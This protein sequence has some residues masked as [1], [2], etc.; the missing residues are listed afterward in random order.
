MTDTQP[1]GRPRGYAVIDTETSG[2]FDFSKPA[3]A[4]GQ[5]RLASFAAIRLD[6]DLNEEGANEYLIKPEGWILSDEVMKIN[7]LTME[8]LEKEGRPV[9]DVLKF[10]SALIERGYVI[11]A[12]NSQFDCKVMRGEMRRAGV[13]DLF[14]AT[15]NICA[16]RAAV[17]VVK[18]PKASGRGYKF[19]KLS[20]AC[21]HFG[22][23]QTEQHSAMADA[24]AATAIFLE[25]KALG[26][27]PDPAVHYAKNRPDA[28]SEAPIQSSP[29]SEAPQSIGSNNPPGPIGFASETMT[30]LSAWMADH[31][32]ILT[33]EDARGARLFVDRAKAAL[34]AMETE[35]DAKVRP[36]NEQVSTINLTYKTLHNS[37]TKK[38]GTF[39]KVFSELKARLA[40]FLQDEE[41]KRIEA[42]KEAKRLADDAEKA[43]REA[44][45]KEAEALQNAQVG[46]VGINVAEVTKEA[47]QAFDAFQ[48]ASR[49]AQVA[50]RDTRVK[51]GGGFGPA[52]GL[53]TK[54]VLVLTDPEAA[55][56]AIGPTEK[57]RDAILSSAR[58][59][60]AL[61]GTLPAGVTEIEERVL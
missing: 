20:E 37:D 42:A 12:F 41:D 5:P 40:K 1:A 2:L 56:K 17:D 7:G 10:Y 45:I 58:D 36:L 46:E 44:E 43:A 60:K 59:Y 50:E 48:R 33:E 38:P 47:D 57:I 11:V 24:H 15:P 61:R 19:P 52:L 8:R 18:A 54:K 29:P 35:R 13:P 30:A 28:V 25:L 27:C 16:M 51:V 53:R 4:E 26:V 9:A 32:V 55:L 21:A 23:E 31:P 6:A 34:D 49:F 39:D 22:I 3:D 14:E